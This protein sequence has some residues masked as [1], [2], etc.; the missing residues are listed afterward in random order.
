MRIFVLVRVYWVCGSREES[1]NQFSLEATELSRTL[2]QEQFSRAEA[3][4]LQAC[5]MN[6][7]PVVETNASPGL[8]GKGLTLHAGLSGQYIVYSFIY[9]RH[10]KYLMLDHSSEWPT[11]SK[12]QLHLFTF[13]NLDIQ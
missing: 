12:F 3:D 2:I 1:G 13:Q 8:T 9:L 6:G 4:A 7:F 5:R 11:L 10:L